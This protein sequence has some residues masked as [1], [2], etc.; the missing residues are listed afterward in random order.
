MTNSA[1]RWPFRCT[2]CGRPSP[3]G[4]LPYCCPTC[5]GVFDLAQPIRYQPASGQP[6]DSGLARYRS[7][8]PLAEQATLITMGEGGTP[9]VAATVDGRSLHFKCEQ[10][11]PTGSFKDRGSAVPVSALLLRV[12]EAIG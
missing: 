3:D 9:L 11:N 5:G 8:L 2:N 12:R 10:L 4:P 1:Y 7:L 6:H